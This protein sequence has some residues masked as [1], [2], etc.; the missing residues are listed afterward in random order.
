LNGDR[1]NAIGVATYAD[2]TADELLALVK[3]HIEPRGLTAG[4]GGRIAL[5]DGLIHH[6][7]IRRALDLPREVPAERLRCALQFAPI[8]PPIH[9]RKRIRGLSL[10]NAS[11][12]VQDEAKQPHPLVAFAWATVVFGSTACSQVAAWHTPPA[13]YAKPQ[14]KNL[15]RIPIWPINHQG[16]LCPDVTAGAGSFAASLPLA[17]DAARDSTPAPLV[18]IARRQGGTPSISVSKEKLRNVRMSTMSPRTPTLSSEG[19]TATVLIKSAATRISTPSSST[20]PMNS[21]SCA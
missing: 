17:L 9:A 20:P 16:Y 2:H 21:R 10:P 7:D 6:Q 12:D 15:P 13:S 1:V 8:A 5:T 4:F 18:A 19:V 14:I 11:A 3:D